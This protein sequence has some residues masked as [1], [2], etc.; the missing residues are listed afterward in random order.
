M[1]AELVKT[2]VSLKVHMFLVNL[3]ILLCP[4]VFLI[5]SNSNDLVLPC[6][7]LCKQF[8]GANHVD[9]STR[10][11]SYWGCRFN[12][13]CFCERFEQ[14]QR[15]LGKASWKKAAKRRKVV[16]EHC[17]N[18]T[19]YELHDIGSIRFIV[20]NAAN[21]GWIFVVHHANTRWFASKK[22]RQIC[23]KIFLRN[24]LQLCFWQNMLLLLGVS[25]SNFLPSKKVSGCPS[26][27]YTWRS[28]DTFK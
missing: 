15:N 7:L 8:C 13:R 22:H 2:C 17:P 5:C 27:T 16:Q 6:T 14:K 10:Q 26:Q 24:K 12:H 21:Q 20:R 25:C 9:E 19:W 4:F 18:P 1:W 23:G 28:L 11:P 3:C